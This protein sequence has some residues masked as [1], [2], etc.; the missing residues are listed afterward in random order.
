MAKGPYLTPKIKR[1]T[2]Q[3]YSEDHQIKP[4]KARESLLKKMKAEG[5]DE[6]FGSNFPSVS[7]VSKHLKEYRDKDEARSLE[8]KGLDKPWSTFSLREYQK[9]YPP[10]YISGFGGE[11]L[12]VVTS[13]F[14]RLSGP[15]V[16]MALPIIYQLGPC[17][18]F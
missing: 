13:L 1:L 4:T 10:Y 5:L 16:S 2:A 18:L 14:E 9:P 11:R 3:I 7:T 6:I 8:S 15:L 17:I 12:W